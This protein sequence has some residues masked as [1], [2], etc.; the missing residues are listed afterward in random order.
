[1]V[2]LK[3]NMVINILFTDTD[4]LMCDFSKD[5]EMFDFSNYSRKSKY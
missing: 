2:S 5:K 1:M 4:I 3:T